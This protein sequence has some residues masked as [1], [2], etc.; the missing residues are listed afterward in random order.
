MCDHDNV[1]NLMT[2]Y[3][4]EMDNTEK[5]I[6]KICN[7]E[8]IKSLSDKDDIEFIKK[9]RREKRFEGQNWKKFYVF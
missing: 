5:Y 4:Q 1:K 7:N 2:M 9:Y 6:C 8:V 3:Y